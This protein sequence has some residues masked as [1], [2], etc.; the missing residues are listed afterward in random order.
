MGTIHRVH[1]GDTVEVF[2]E[3]GQTTVTHEELA[4]LLVAEPEQD[5]EADE[6]PDPID[7][8]AT[9]GGPAILDEGVTPE[10]LPTNYDRATSGSEAEGS[11]PKGEES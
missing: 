5:A 6:T 4:H 8:P 1:P 7:P 11:D 2:G 9:G 10:P 3:H